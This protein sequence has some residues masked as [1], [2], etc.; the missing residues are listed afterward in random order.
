MAIEDDRSNCQTQPNRSDQTGQMFS[1]FGDV[2]SGD[3][4]E[5]VPSS[6]VQK[7]KMDLLN[8]KN[9]LI[10]VYFEF[11]IGENRKRYT[12]FVD[13]RSPYTLITLDFCNQIQAENPDVRLLFMKSTTR[14]IGMADGPYKIKIGGTCCMRIYAKDS[15]GTEIEWEM[16]HVR[17]VKSLN[18]R[19]L[20]GRQSLEEYRGVVDYAERTVT[21]THP[22]TGI[23]HLIQGLKPKDEARAFACI[24]EATS[25]PTPTVTRDMKDLMDM[26]E[27]PEKEKL[28][29][30]SILQA[31]NKVFSDRTGCCSVYQHKL[32]MDLNT[33]SM[34]PKERQI[35][36]GQKPAVKKHIDK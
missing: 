28:F 23:K 12:V 21:I 10:G 7:A 14:E 30:R 34:N 1:L 5:F 31:Y 20:M 32:N 8:N 13:G 25:L 9:Y 2:E 33:P 17:V 24:Q 29:F 4:E 11:F 26:L 6:P 19:F 16:N 15:K 27:I 3:E 35:P 22:L 36:Y 18:T